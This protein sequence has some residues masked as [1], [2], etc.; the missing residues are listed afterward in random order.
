MS[1]CASDATLY[2]YYCEALEDGMDAGPCSTTNTLRW[3]CCAPG[4]AYSTGSLA[5]TVEWARRQAMSVARAQ[6]N[7][8]MGS[9]RT[10]VRRPVEEVALAGITV[11]SPVDGAC[12]ALEHWLVESGRLR[13]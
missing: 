12:C 7:V 13:G 3:E 11:L 4:C 1:H 10:C 8:S 2:L 9:T 5:L 6:T